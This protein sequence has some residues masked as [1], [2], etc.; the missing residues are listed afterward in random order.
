MGWTNPV[1]VLAE[2]K[3]FSKLSIL[4]VGLTQPPIQ[5][6]LGFF[7]GGKAASA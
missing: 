2:V 1:Q 4:T 3:I 5:W 6:V 7:P